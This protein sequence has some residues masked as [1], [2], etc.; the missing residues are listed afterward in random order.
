[1]KR[2][3]AKGGSAEV[4]DAVREATETR[5]RILGSFDFSAFRDAERLMGCLSR[6]DVVTA[7][8]GEAP[9]IKG[10]ARLGNGWDFGTYDRS[11]REIAEAIMRVQEALGQ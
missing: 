4:R 6:W 8:Q 5:R 9:V 11:R 7:T 2:A 10:K 3:E 1:M